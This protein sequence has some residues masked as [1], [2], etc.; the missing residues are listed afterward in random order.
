MAIVLPPSSRLGEAA[1]NA[2]VRHLADLDTM[3]AGVTTADVDKVIHDTRTGM[4]R[5][6]ALLRLIRSSIG[7]PAY[8][9]ANLQSKDLAGALAG[10]RDARALLDTVGLLLPEIENRACRAR[11]RSPFAENYCLA[12]RSAVELQPLRHAR[13]WLRRL[14]REPGQ[15]QLKRFDRHALMHAIESEYDQGRAH[16]SQIQQCPEASELHEWRKEVKRFYYQMSLLFPEGNNAQRVRLKQLGEYLGQLHDLHILL[17]YVAS[18]RSLFWT[19]DLLHLGKV[20]QW[21]EQVLMNMIWRLAPKAYGD[22]APRYSRKLIKRWR[23]LGQ[24][25]H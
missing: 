8:R 5:M 6:R 17:E 11:L 16:W 24:K 22:P 1:H 14:Q 18:H 4:K 19:D 3:L 9:T 7:K 12:C 2:I 10:N 21:R 23:D 15:W 20:A 13:R 25:K